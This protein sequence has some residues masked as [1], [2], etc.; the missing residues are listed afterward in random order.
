MKSLNCFGA[1]RT[2]L[3]VAVLSALVACGGGGGSD[4]ADPTVTLSGVAAKG[5][6]KNAIVR[7]YRVNSDGSQT[8][9]KESVT[10]TDGSYS[11]A[12][13]PAGV[14]VLVEISAGPSTTMVD[15]A[16]NATDVPVP[17]GFRIRAATTTVE[18]GTNTLQVT[19]F[20]EMAVT[21][22]EGAEG[23]LVPANIEGANADIRT[24]LGFDVLA[25]RPDFSDD[26]TAPENKAA[27]MLAA[28]SQLA[29][30]ATEV[31]NLGCDSED[32]TGDRIKCVIEKLADGGTDDDA[33]ADKLETAKDEVV[34]DDFA[35]TD[36]DIPPAPLPQPTEIVAPD[37][38]ATAISEA[39]ALIAG[40]RANAPYL[41][42]SGSDT[43]DKRLR[44]VEQTINAAANPVNP[45]SLDLYQGV[46]QGA[47]WLSDG[48]F[49]EAGFPI[50]TQR[51]IASGC[52]FFTSTDPTVNTAA[53]NA[54]EANAVGCR[55]TYHVAQKQNGNW[56]AYQHGFRV[57]KTDTANT[58]AVYSQVV[59]QL[60]N[61]ED[62]S[63]D[64]SSPSNTVRY[65][66]DSAALVGSIVLSKDG[67]GQT[68]GVSMTGDYA[69]GVRAALQGF[70]AK[71]VVTATVTPT[72]VAVGDIEL[73]R[74]NLTGSFVSSGGSKPSGTVQ[75]ASGSYLQS[76]LLTPGDIHSGEVDGAIAHREAKLVLSA[77][78]GEASVTGTLTL[79]AFSSSADVP[80]QELPTSIAFQG[81]V[82]QNASTTLFDGTVTAS[83]GGDVGLGGFMVDAPV[84]VD[85]FVQ[86]SV[87][88][89][90]ALYVPS[91]P[92]MT[93][94]LT[95][96]SP[97]FQHYTL[98]GSYAQSGSSTVLVSGAG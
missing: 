42:G 22:A 50:N 78:A 75:L 74:L 89:E 20:S 90:G 87:A 21:K 1:V 86:A 77:G 71:T 61:P 62:M 68:T 15:E 47:Q 38:R 4:A 53:A 79:S 24:Y 57:V 49:A 55:M 80:T 7:A 8:L 6:L 14:T 10:D 73:T 59:E 70:A 63:M 36:D 88:F 41:G 94:N 97:S 83:A 3:S 48:M 9:I 30:N 37:L 16:T 85:N 25:E 31:D 43:L 27:L 29:N 66:L 18:G 67:S 82:K 58:Y 56:Y 54:D 84:T 33:L 96:S 46:L 12:D 64:T 45:T 69:A 28:V 39:K 65:P 40:I 91:R 2:A 19:P 52:T 23:G 92:I 76:R 81:V 51:A 44:A 13:I 72:T 5:L 95:L 26:G 34:N 93:V 98:S 60:L 11:L 32:D 35:G 17:A